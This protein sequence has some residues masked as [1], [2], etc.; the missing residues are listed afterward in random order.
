MVFEFKFRL[1]VVSYYLVAAVG[2]EPTTFRSYEERV[3][4]GICF[5]LL[6]LI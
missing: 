6:L 3:R 4:G 5:L 1:S 2:C